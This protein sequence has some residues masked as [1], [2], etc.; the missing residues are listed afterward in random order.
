MKFHKNPMNNFNIE[1]PELFYTINHLREEGCVFQYSQEPISNGRTVIVNNRELLQ[2]ASCSYLGLEKHP[3]LVEGL[4]DAARK[5]GTQTPSSR[6][7]ISSPLYKELEENLSKIFPGY[8]IVTQ[9]VTLAHCS[10]LPLLIGEKDA[11]IMDAYAHNSIRMAAQLCS[12]NGT[13]IINS[14]HNDMEHVKYLIYRLK[15]EGYRNIWYCGDGIYSIHGNLCDVAGLQKLLDE[16][17]NFYAYIDDAHGTGWCGKNGSGYVIG[18]YGLHNKMIVTES[19]AK[20]MAT[21]GGGIIVPNKELADYIR[22]TGQTMIFSGPI[23][24][25][26]L[27]ALV[28]CTKLHLSHEIEQMQKEF[29]ELIEYFIK[30]SKELLLPIVTK[31]ATPIQLLRI[32]GM[33]NTYKVLK[34]LIENGF[35]SMTAGYP[36]ISSGD[37]GIRITLTRHLKKEDIDMFLK[38]IKSIL[39][40]ENISV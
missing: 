13:F 29:F 37:E 27:G 22:Y 25:A 33:E 26:I 14:K 39:Y 40:T 12:A 10:V 16:E 20:S 1:I 21:S 35:F 17:G 18:T 9:T 24:P 4:M 2:F 7:M 11:I 5:Y 31:D 36:A 6:A 38:N 23:Q 32:G 8:Q 19:F 28:A 30:R 34:K 15:K 3:I